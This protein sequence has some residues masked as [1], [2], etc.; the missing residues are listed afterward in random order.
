[1]PSPSEIVARLLE[2]DQPVDTRDFILQAG[3]ELLAAVA[4]GE[5]TF[6][7]ALEARTFYHKTAVYA[8]GKRPIEARRNGRTQIWKTRPGIFRI[9]IRVGFREQSQI[10]NY[11]HKNADQWST[12]PPVHT[13]PQPRIKIPF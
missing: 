13:T 1:M 6:Q 7:A 2:D 11:F 3:D 12:I 5:I 10:D 8:D 9:P 4:K